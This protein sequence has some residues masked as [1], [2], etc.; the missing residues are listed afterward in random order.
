MNQSVSKARRAVIQ[1]SSQKKWALEDAWGG[2]LCGRHPYPESRRGNIP[3]VQAPAKMDR[4]QGPKPNRGRWSVSLTVSLPGDLRGARGSLAHVGSSTKDASPS[5]C[6]PQSQHHPREKPGGQVRRAWET[7]SLQYTALRGW[8][9]PAPPP[10]PPSSA[11]SLLN[12]LAGFQTSQEAAACATPLPS[13]P[14]LL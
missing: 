10:T 11:S 5:L 7:L 14:L 13:P 12:T 2:R 3:E 1:A 8:S 6:T 9:W 4:S